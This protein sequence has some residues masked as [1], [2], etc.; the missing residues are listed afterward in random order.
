[1]RGTR[2]CWVSGSPGIIPMLAIKAVARASATWLRCRRVVASVSCNGGEECDYFSIIEN[3]LPFGFS[4]V[5]RQPAAN[6]AGGRLLRK[7][8]GRLSR[9]LGQDRMSLK[10]ALGCAARFVAQRNIVSVRT[11]SLPSRYQ[12]ASHWPAQRRW[13]DQSGRRD[14]NPRQPAWKAGCSEI[15]ARLV[16]IGL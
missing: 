13:K 5:G 14:S 2:A 7:K 3:V 8:R 12:T 10:N 15:T 9:T 4:S 6:G 11:V 16:H 1:M